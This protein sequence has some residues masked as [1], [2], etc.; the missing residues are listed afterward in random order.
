M[1]SSCWFH[2]WLISLFRINIRSELKAYK[3]LCGQGNMLFWLF[4]CRRRRARP[5]YLQS[6]DTVW[7]KCS[8]QYGYMCHVKLYWHQHKNDNWK[9][10]Y[11]FGIFISPST[12]FLQIDAPLQLGKSYSVKLPIPLW[13]W[14]RILFTKRA[15]TEADSVIVEYP[16]GVSWWYFGLQYGILYVINHLS[17]WP[18]QL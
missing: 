15:T 17:L 5:S 16:F 14:D 10:Y 18:S 2:L 6:L 11:S 4:P 9:L 1:L 12:R 7:N 8:H 13:Q 3:E